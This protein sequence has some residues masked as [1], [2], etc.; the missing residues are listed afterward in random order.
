MYWVCICVC[1]GLSNQQPGIF[2]KI[3]G[4]CSPPPL[5][6]SFLIL[7]AKKET[8]CLQ[9]AAAEGFD[10]WKPFLYCICLT[11]FDLFWFDEYVSSLGIAI[12]S[13]CAVM[14]VINIFTE[15]CNLKFV[16]FTVIGKCCSLSG[17]NEGNLVQF[18]LFLNNWSVL[19]ICIISLS[20]Q[21][22]QKLRM[23]K[24]QYK[25]IVSVIE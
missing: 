25:T 17:E 8:H 9:R 24:T 11:S 22:S 19:S 6:V 7:W 10:S 13:S 16:L 18:E 4:I 15:R 5:S 21:A 12:A 2:R 1:V 14:T 20:K 23:K 3:L